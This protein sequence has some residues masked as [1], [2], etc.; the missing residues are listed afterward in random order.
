MSEKV[1][2][3][4]NCPGSGFKM[5]QKWH[6]W[7]SDQSLL[8]LC[9]DETVKC[10]LCHTGNILMSRSPC[11]CFNYCHGNAIVTIYRIYMKLV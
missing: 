6:G 1:C 10:G 5:N 7:T 2:E 4:V 3:E 11:T 8:L 9:N